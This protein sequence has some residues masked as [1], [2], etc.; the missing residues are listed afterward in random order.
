TS[1]PAR[2]RCRALY[3]DSSVLYSFPTRR[4][5]DLPGTPRVREFA[6]PLIEGMVAHL[7]E[8]DERIRRYCEN[9]EFHRISA[10]DRNVL[11]LAIYRSEEHTSELQSPDHLVCRL[12]LDKIK[13]YYLL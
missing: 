3:R 1:H 6:Q 9:Y 2:L 10:V 13:T 8:V 5:S 4:S 7:P 12:L 11:R